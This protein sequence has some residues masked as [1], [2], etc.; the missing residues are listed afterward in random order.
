MAVHAPF[1][2]V[3][4]RSTHVA[5]STRGQQDLTCVHDQRV[6]QF[7]RLSTGSRPRQGGTLLPKDFQLF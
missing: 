2:H 5:V 1:V 6:L 3:F 7:Q 4:L